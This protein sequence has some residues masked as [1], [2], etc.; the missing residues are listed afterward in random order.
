VTLP[1]SE[2]NNA[3]LSLYTKQLQTNMHGRRDIALP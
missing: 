3:L 2:L 1:V